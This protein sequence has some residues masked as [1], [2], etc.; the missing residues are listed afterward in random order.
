MEIQKIQFCYQPH[1]HLALAPVTIRGVNYK[2]DLS[3]SLS[4]PFCNPN[5]QIKEMNLKDKI[6]LHSELC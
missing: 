2:E 3:F 6:V 1:I 5:S 4:L